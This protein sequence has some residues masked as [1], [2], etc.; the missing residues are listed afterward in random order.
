MMIFLPDQS[1]RTTLPNGMRKIHLPTTRTPHSLVELGLKAIYSSPEFCQ[2]VCDNLNDGM[3]P[4]EIQARI[5]DGPA[6]KCGNDAC[7]S[8]LF[9][10]CYFLLLKKNKSLSHIIFSNMFCSMDCTNRW[11]NLYKEKYHKIN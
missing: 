9:T 5:M 4:H 6:T 1:K 11:L 7:S 2:T 3:I 10:E 8:L